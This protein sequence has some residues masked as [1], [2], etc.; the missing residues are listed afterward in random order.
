MSNP[1]TNQILNKSLV[2]GT[3]ITDAL[4]TLRVTQGDGSG[5]MLRSVYDADNDGKVDVANVAEAVAWTGVTGKPTLF[6]AQPYTH[7]HAISEVT[8]LQDALDGKQETLVN[9]SNIKSVN[10]ASL[11]GSGNITITSGVTDHGVLTGLTDDDHTQYHNDARGDARYSLLSH[12]HTATVISN[13]PSG[14][15]AATTVQDAIN[16][17]DS[18]KAAVAAV[19][20]KLTAARTYYVR[21]DGSDSNNGLANTSGGAFLTVQKAI[22]V[23]SALDNGGFNITIQLGNGTYSAGAS[24]KSFVGSGRIVIQGNS[25]TPANVHVSV[26]SGNVVAGV[27]VIGVYEISYMKLTS[28]AAGNLVS[29][30]GATTSVVLRGNVYGSAGGGTVYAHV[31]VQDN[32]SIDFGSVAYAIDGGAGYHLYSST[33]GI[34]NCN[35]LTVTLTGTPAFAGA[36]AYA[37]MTGI[38]RAVSNTYTGA[39]TGKRYEALSNGIVQTAAGATVLPGNVAGTTATGGLYL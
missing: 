4:N 34:I 25:T 23:A 29:L 15:I 24:L 16:E 21:T 10:G 30:S 6:P 31:S 35:V 11:L 36:Y 12:T 18:E 20:E 14:N 32:A 5:D 28:A 8:G 7:N 26:A 2:P 38:T 9:G 19:R 39:A 3:T 13:T 33:G 27:S 22:D 37:S 17:L 1:T